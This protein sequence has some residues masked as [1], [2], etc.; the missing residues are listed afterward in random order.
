MRLPWAHIC[1]LSSPNEPQGQLWTKLL[2]KGGVCAAEDWVVRQLQHSPCLRSSA[3]QAFLAVS[4]SQSVFW[5]CWLGFFPFASS[6]EL[7]PLKYPHYSPGSSQASSTPCVGVQ[8]LREGLCPTAGHCH[9]SILE[10]TRQG[11][12]LGGSGEL[13]GPAQLYRGLPQLLLLF[14]T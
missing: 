6:G 8:A 10:L 2:Q 7:F 14:V 1:I 3:A 9:R 4:C 12:G 11:L 5:W 13:L